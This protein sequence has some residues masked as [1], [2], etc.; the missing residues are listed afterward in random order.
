MI[1]I[2]GAPPALG[3]SRKPATP[4]TTGLWSRIDASRRAGKSVDL[5]ASDPRR[6][7]SPILLGVLAV[8]AV[9]AL[10]SLRDRSDSRAPVAAVSTDTDERSLRLAHDAGLGPGQRYLRRCHRSI[11]PT[12]PA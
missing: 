11:R 1:K 2:A 10:A 9:A 3:S 8:A 4:T 6:P 12:S 5:P 7:V